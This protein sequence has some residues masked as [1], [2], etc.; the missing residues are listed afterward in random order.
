[1]LFILLNIIIP[2]YYQYFPLILFNSLTME[3]ALK[4]VICNLA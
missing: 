4:I 3:I 2:F 1:M